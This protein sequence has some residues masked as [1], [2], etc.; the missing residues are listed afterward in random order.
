MPCSE[1]TGGQLF[2]EDPNGR[3]RLSAGGP[4]GHM[5]S[6]QEVTSFEPHRLHATL[7]WSGTRLL[8][9]AHHIGQYRRL[10][11]SAWRSLSLCG[12]HPVQC[13]ENGQP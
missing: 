4:Q 3:T 13:D 1:F 10:T 9:V 2:V 5:L 8:L 7:P 12:F 6:L 11:D